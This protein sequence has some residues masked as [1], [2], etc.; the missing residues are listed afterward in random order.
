MI[1]HKNT[2]ALNGKTILPFFSGCNSA[3]ARGMASAQ[4]NIYIYTH[5]YIYMLSFDI[6]S[7]EGFGRED[8]PVMTA[9]HIK[10]PCK[11]PW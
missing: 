9:K 6:I 10:E 3:K 7:V 1:S 2:P 11:E 4:L 5:I 8:N